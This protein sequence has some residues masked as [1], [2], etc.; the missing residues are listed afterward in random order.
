MKQQTKKRLA[1]AVRLNV[2]LGVLVDFSPHLA[3]FYSWQCRKAFESRENQNCP[4]KAR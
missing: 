2:L 1:A 4:L 3:H